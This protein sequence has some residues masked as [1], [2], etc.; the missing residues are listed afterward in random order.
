VTVP[1]A[2]L[3][4]VTGAVPAAS[5]SIRNLSASVGLWSGR[6]RGLT[7][8]RRGL[9][10]GLAGALATLALP[11]FHLLPVLWISFPLLFWLLQGAGTAAR[12]GRTAFWTGWWFG[13]G[14]F[15]TGLYWISVALWTDIARWWW[16]LPLATAGLP[17]LMAGMTGLAAAAFDR[18]RRRFSATGVAEIL[19]LA[20]CWSA[21]ELLRG[22]AFT[23]FPWNLTGY[24]WTGFLPV[25]QS[26]AVIGVYGLSLLTVMIAALPALISDRPRSWLPAVAG[27]VVLGL[28]AAAGAWRMEGTA[29]RFVPDVTL[30]LVQANVPQAAKWRA[31]AA[32]RNL[33]RHL[34]LSRQPPAAGGPAPTHILWPETAVPFLF[35][36]DV[37]LPRRLAEAVPA[38]GLLLTGG[39]RILA[40][41]D[42][43]RAYANSL[44]LIDEN[45][46]ISQTYDKSHLVPFGEYLPF[47]RFLP[48]GLKAVAAV[49]ADATPGPG[50]QTLRVAGLPPFSP[51]ICYE[52]IFPAAVRP[53]G[54]TELPRWLLN[55]TND[56]WYGES[57]GP[58]QH[59][60]ISLTRAVEEGVP[61]VR[62]AGTGI[63]AVVDPYGRIVASIPLAQSGIVDV[64]LP[65][66]S[67]LATVFGLVGNILPVMLIIGVGLV[68]FFLSRRV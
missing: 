49:G 1:A 24:A 7:G 47:R 38:Q 48:D 54:G 20:V 68:V 25:L 42:G 59:F 6:V 28:V 18:L 33:A 27:L 39:V 22:H 36:G 19:L 10:A 66:T 67:E 34:S 8:W 30:R 43:R 16:V 32:E 11:P 65:A 50:P 62:V 44:I 58:Y 37:A 5:F 31:D 15:V 23:G 56:A 51:L 45:G 12:P 60:A 41:G 2:S 63:S 57:S 21:G 40:D 46:D 13:F 9:A 14:H 55:I 17:A 26:V 4:G 64:G 29:G 35:D 53:T 3:A 61:L 52:V